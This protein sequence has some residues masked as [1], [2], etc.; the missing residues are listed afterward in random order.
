MI[1]LIPVGAF[2]VAGYAILSVIDPPPTVS[3]ATL[4]IINA[5]LIV[6]G[7]IALSQFVLAPRFANLRLIN[8]S[9]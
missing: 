6:L 4:A 1:W 8:A 3:L 7:V 9:A 5:T 2:G